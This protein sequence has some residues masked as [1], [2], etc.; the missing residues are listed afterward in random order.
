MESNVSVRCMCAFILIIELISI[1]ACQCRCQ[2]RVILNLFFIF[3][4]KRNNEK[5][6]MTIHMSCITYTW[7][8]QVQ[9]HLNFSTLKIHFRWG[10]RFLQFLIYSLFLCKSFLSVLVFRFFL[11][12]VVYS[13]NQELNE[14]ICL[15]SLTQK[16]KLIWCFGN[17]FID[18]NFDQTNSFA[19]VLDDEHIE[20][21]T[22]D[23]QWFFLYFDF[24]VEKNM[25]LQQL[26]STTCDNIY[27]KTIF[28]PFCL[29]TF[30]YMLV[31]WISHRTKQ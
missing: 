22:S 28:L 25:I 11:F 30:K 5:F 12:N 27:S 14:K 8:C 20:F 10:D 2:K 7:K 31:R 15:L 26:D 19:N 24:V 6:A 1:W 16:K 17:L 4:R 3:K 23:I 13:K 29:C 21:V 9:I 18:F